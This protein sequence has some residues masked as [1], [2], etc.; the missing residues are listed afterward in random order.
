MI[1]AGG[2]EVN[3]EGLDL[4]VDNLSDEQ[5]TAFLYLL[6]DKAGCV[7]MAKLMEWIGE[8]NVVPIKKQM[9]NIIKIP[10]STRWL[11]QYE[12]AAVMA[13]L[14]FSP[15][16]TVEWLTSWKFIDEDQDPREDSLENAVLNVYRF[17]K[18]LLLPRG[19]CPFCHLAGVNNTC[20]ETPIH[21][22]FRLSPET[23]KLILS[24]VKRYVN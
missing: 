21:K 18:L 1:P 7:G 12:I 17:G 8:Y 19:A 2:I 23:I 9:Y 15:E 14:G 16:R 13:Y 11:F 5:I 20:N 6:F 4:D 10:R 3:V 24:F 22:I